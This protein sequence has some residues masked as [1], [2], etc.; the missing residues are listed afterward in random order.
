MYLLL[1]FILLKSG[2]TE[3]RTSIVYG[4]DARQICQ[5]SLPLTISLYER[6]RFHDGPPSLLIKEVKGRCEP[7]N[8]NN[9][10]ANKE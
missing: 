1:I 4:E 8:D 5:D 2:G 3:V 10:L 7:V 9:K 6:G